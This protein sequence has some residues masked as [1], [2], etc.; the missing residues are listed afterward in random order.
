MKDNKAGEEWASFI[1]QLSGVIA[2]P[3]HCLVKSVKN[4][5]GVKKNIP[6]CDVLKRIV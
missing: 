1:K 4:D 5:I 6:K 2:Q 3:T